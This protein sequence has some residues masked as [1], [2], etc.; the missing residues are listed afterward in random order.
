MLGAKGRGEQSLGERAETEEPGA[1]AEPE[2][3]LKP[4]AEMEMGLLLIDGWVTA[5]R[6]KL[7]M[8]PFL[9]SMFC[10]RSQSYQIHS[11]FAPNWESPPPKFLDL[12][13]CFKSTQ[14]SGKQFTYSC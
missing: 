8:S 10:C 5:E 12:V 1:E 4:G 11:E 14:N 3:R 6:I 7:S 9:S 13:I 2:Q